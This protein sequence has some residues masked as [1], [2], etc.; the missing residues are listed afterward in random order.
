MAFGISGF[1]A[2][3]F[4]SGFLNGIR[5]GHEMNR[6]D[7][8]DE[9]RKADRAETRAYRNRMMD[10]R[11]QTLDMNAELNQLRSNALKDEEFMRR[12]KFVSKRVRAAM[13]D[14]N[15]SP[16]T[17]E[18]FK[19]LPD[20]E[21]M[22]RIDTMNQ[23][24]AWFNNEAGF[25]KKYLASS[26]S[27]AINPDK[28]VAGYQLLE[29]DQ[30]N[31][32]VL[33]HL[34]RTDGETGPLDYPGRKDGQ[35]TIMPVE[36]F[37]D[38]LWNTS[39]V[40]D[41]GKLTEKEKLKLLE[42]KETRLADRKHKYRMTENAAKP[43]QPTNMQRNIEYLVS[44]GLAKNK[45]EALKITQRA[46]SNPTKLVADMVEASEENQLM[47]QVKPGDPRY[48]S[49]EQM[50]SE[51]Y[52][53]IDQISGKESEAQPAPRV[54][55][56]QEGSDGVLPPQAAQQLREGKVTSFGNGQQW[57]LDSGRPVRV[58]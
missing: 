12:G 4:S 56:G 3:G 43:V 23:G 1:G 46:K 45:S 42:D 34:N 50:I 24:A 14:R 38:L 11:Q 19:S 21:R 26:P 58:K 7:R 17:L 48:R 39:G 22:K 29:S 57:T 49:R 2:K 28:P 18:A 52:G 33:T 31:L 8:L 44:N 13:S 25:M 5:T 54:I 27:G 16:L 6:Q 15:G 10:Q 35:G 32:G 20:D 41:D 37:S 53:L 30:G 36:V 40:F 51:A 9:E 55:Q 47:F